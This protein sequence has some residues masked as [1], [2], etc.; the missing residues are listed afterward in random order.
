MPAKKNTKNKNNNGATLGIENELREAADK[1]RGHLDAAKIFYLVS[2][3]PRE[4]VCLC[5]CRPDI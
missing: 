4:G 1:L 5:Y 2:M 3:S